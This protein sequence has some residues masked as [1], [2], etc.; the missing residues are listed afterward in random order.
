MK[1]QLVIAALTHPGK[2]RAHNEDFVFADAAAGFAVLADGMG[3]HNAGEVASRMA[4]E[5]VSDRLAKEVQGG[6]IRGAAH[7]EALL[8]EHLALA[9]VALLQASRSR[10]EYDGMGTTVVAVL[11]HAAGV[12]FGHVGDSR[13]YVLRRGELRQ[14]T[15]DHSIVQEQVE[16]GAITAEDARYAPNRNVLTRAVGIDAGAKADVHTAR[17]E[18]GDVYLLCSDGL[19]DMLT[20]D[21]VRKTLLSSPGALETAAERLIERANQMG[22]IDNISVIIAG[23]IAVAAEVVA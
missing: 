7:A 3:G 16:S 15:R 19:T 2:V 17:V 11:W 20:D 6:P 12:T 13:L 21:E 5:L 1:P 9:N 10:P 18:T 23:V 14:L 8:S 22:G 4:V